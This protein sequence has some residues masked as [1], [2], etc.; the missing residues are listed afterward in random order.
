MDYTRRSEMVIKSQ[1]V[2]QTT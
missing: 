2:S 1:A